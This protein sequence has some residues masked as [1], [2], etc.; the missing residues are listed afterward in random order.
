M[1]R[2]ICGGNWQK[3]AIT[4]GL[5][6]TLANK[7]HLDTTSTKTFPL[8]MKMKKCFSLGSM[9]SH[10]KLRF[11]KACA[12]RNISFFDNFWSIFCIGNRL[13]VIISCPPSSSS[14]LMRLFN[15]FNILFWF[16]LFVVVCSQI[17]IVSLLHPLWH[18]QYFVVVV[19]ASLLPPPPPY[20]DC[21]S[22]KGGQ[23]R[24]RRWRSPEVCNMIK[25]HPV[26]FFQIE[27]SSFS[28]NLHGHWSRFIQS[29]SS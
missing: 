25:I 23:T 24:R 26:S 17:S 6:I 5:S 20:W 7:V 9:P 10:C 19:I 29:H 8:R 4:T 11:L 18:F 2:Y 14:A 15:M 3:L 16:F 13:E 27:P 21:S 1:L 22:C 28:F 12:L